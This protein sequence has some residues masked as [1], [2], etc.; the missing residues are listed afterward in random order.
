MRCIDSLAKQ[1]CRLNEIVVVDNA[2]DRRVERILTSRFSRL[3]YL[4]MEDN[5]GPAGGFAEGIEYALKEGH[6]WI[7][8]FTDDGETDPGALEALLATIAGDSA[9]GMVGF[10]PANRWRGRTVA[11]RPTETGEDSIEVDLV[12]ARG[13][14]SV[15]SCCFEGFALV[16]PAERSG[17]SVVVLDEG[18]HF[19]GE[20]FGGGEVASAEEAMA[21]D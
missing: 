19:C 18:D 8:L 21:Q 14:P 16:G 10:F 7:W 20:F 2:A 15:I 4:P 9:P 12:L 11:V 17:S 3:R 5:L 1:S 13:S 6:V